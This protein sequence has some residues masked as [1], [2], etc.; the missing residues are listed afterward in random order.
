MT[1][2]RERASWLLAL[3]V[4]LPAQAAT[5]RSKSLAQFDNGYAQCEQRDPAMR[6]HR[7]QV[8]ASLYRLKLDDALRAQLEETRKSAPYKT[9]RRRAQ[10]TLARNAAAS[11]VQQRL[12]QQCLA[13]KREIRAPAPAAS[14]ASR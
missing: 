3:A 2:W 12:D 8:Y 1:T 9:E 5:P 4:V 13:L 14:A 10:Q 7:D 6:G 11:D